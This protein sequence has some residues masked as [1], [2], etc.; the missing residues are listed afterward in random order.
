MAKVSALRCCPGTFF[1]VTP[2]QAPDCPNLAKGRGQ[3]LEEPWVTYRKGLSLTLTVEDLAV[4]LPLCEDHGQA[5]VRDAM[6]AAMALLDEWDWK[7]L[8]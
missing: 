7:P 3:A 6:N 5:V 2:W 1:D 8:P 4:V